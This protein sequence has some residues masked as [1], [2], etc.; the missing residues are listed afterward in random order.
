M[1]WFIGI[2]ENILILSIILNGPWLNFQS[3]SLENASK[4]ETAERNSLNWSGATFLFVTSTDH[5]SAAISSNFG[6]SFR[7]TRILS[8][9]L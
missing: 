1:Q 5:K 7:A 3:I 9:D 2:F 6:I 8:A 4:P